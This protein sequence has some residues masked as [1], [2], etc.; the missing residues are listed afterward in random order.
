MRFNKEF[1]INQEILPSRGEFTKIPKQQDE[2]ITNS[3]LMQ[4][5]N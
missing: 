3:K 5:L 1:N 2:G 4:W